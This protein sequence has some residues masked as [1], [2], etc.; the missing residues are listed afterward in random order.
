VLALAPIWPVLAGPWAI[1]GSVDS[2]FELKIKK[3]KKVVDHPPSP[4]LRAHLVNMQNLLPPIIKV[5]LLRI[6]K[7]V[8][9]SLRAV[10][11][12][13][14]FKPVGAS[15]LIAMLRHPRPRGRP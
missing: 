1:R 12:V 2:I 11:G 14:C 4:M 5:W 15:F 6:L 10:L 7:G 13:L 3:K 9:A 8:L